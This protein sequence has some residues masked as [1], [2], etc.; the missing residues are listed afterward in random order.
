MGL[1]CSKNKVASTYLEYM[2]FLRNTNNDIPQRVVRGS[3]LPWSR[4]QECMVGSVFLLQVVKPLDP[5]CV[6]RLYILYDRSD[7][8]V[9]F[10]SETGQYIIAYQHRNC[11]VV[12]QDAFNMLDLTMYRKSRMGPVAPDEAGVS[13]SKTASHPTNPLYITW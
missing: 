5:S 7:T 1:S 3:P 10:L 8:S 13:S 2:R 6:A 12:G 11:A 4:L 9:T